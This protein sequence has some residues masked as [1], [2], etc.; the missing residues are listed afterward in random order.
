VNRTVIASRNRVFRVLGEFAGN[1]LAAVVSRNCARMTRHRSVVLASTC[2]CRCAVPSRPVLDVL[3][4]RG[5][6]AASAR[7]LARYRGAGSAPCWAAM[8][9]PMWSSSRWRS[10]LARRSLP[11]PSCRLFSPSRAAGSTRVALGAAL[12]WRRWAIPGSSDFGRVV[13]VADPRAIDG[14]LVRERSLSWAP[15][16]RRCSSARAKIACASAVRASND[17]PLRHREGASS[18]LNCRSKTQAYE[19]NEFCQFR[20]RRC[21]VRRDEADDTSVVERTTSV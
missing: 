14:V 16:S 17:A 12:P 7:A 20:D 8:A 18:A 6:R 10:L 19:F 21:V 3:E 4:R 2:C 9:Q 15:S 13:D 5:F 11:E 1:Y